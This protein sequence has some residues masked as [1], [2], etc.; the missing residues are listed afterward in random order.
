MALAY[1]FDIFR[2]IPDFGTTD[3][4]L[5]GMLEDFSTGPERESA[6]VALF[7]DP[8]T[9]DA[10]RRA[11]PD[12]RKYLLESGFGLNTYKSGA[13][14]GH[15]PASDEA[16]RLDLIHRLAENAPGFALPGPEEAA[17]GGDV[18]RLGQFLEALDQSQPI[19]ISASD[20]SPPDHQ[21]DH[22]AGPVLP[23]KHTLP[24]LFETEPLADAPVMAETAA[25]RRKFWQSRFFRIGATAVLVLGAMQLASG[26]ALIVLASL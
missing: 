23:R 12:L 20:P 11:P 8:R 9:A 14:A 7:R 25:T 1:D 26:P 13:P 19:D 4:R 16:A 3:P 15:Y 17:E 21:Q 10:L 5:A 18:F 6:T 22:S 24:A 2:I